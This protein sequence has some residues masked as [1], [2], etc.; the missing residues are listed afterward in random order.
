MNEPKLIPIARASADQDSGG[1]A[2]MGARGRAI[3][4]EHLERVLTELIADALRPALEGRPP[5]TTR[6]PSDLFARYVASTFVLVL[7][8]WLESKSL[9]L[10]GEVN[11]LFLRMIEPTLKATLS[12]R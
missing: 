7:N 8:W 11:E 2:R 10:P 3:V 5:T 1:R 12:D 4:H 9:L 6:T